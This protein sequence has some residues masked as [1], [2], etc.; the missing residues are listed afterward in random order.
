[1]PPGPDQATAA[2]F[3]RS[4][5][6][7]KRERIDFLVGGAYALA[8]HTGVERHTRDFDV[9]VRPRD[10]EAT[11]AALAPVCDRTELTFTHW[12]GKAYCGDRYIDVIFNSGNGV[13]EV[14]DEWF[15]HAIDS[16]VFGQEV[17]LVPVEEMIWQK[18]FVMERERFDGADIAHMLRASG[19][20][21]DWV[22][23][24]R[25]FRPHWRVLF[26]HLVLFGFVYPNERGAVPEGVIRSLSERFQ[27]EAGAAPNGRYL[28]QGTLLSREQYLFDLEQWGYQD[29][30]LLPPAQMSEEE[31][32]EWTA[33]IAT[34]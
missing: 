17:R 21:I 30:R 11:L 8:C 31:I 22:R 4:L 19:Q 6:R 20:R 2:F 12:L 18:A 16:T 3:V 27:R 23:L 25:R 9:F 32:A 1:M 5:R 7:L 29:A 15:D 26:A 24:L 28:C 10:V 33:A 34:R 14:D 13:C